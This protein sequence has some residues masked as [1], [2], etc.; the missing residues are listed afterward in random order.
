MK[1]SVI[2][3]VY[4]S[5]EFLPKCLDSILGQD[6]GDFELILVN[7]GTKDG[8][9]AIMEDYARRDTRIRQIHKENG[10]LSSARN[11]GLDIAKGEY[12][13]FV[14]SDDWI[15]PQLLHDAVAAA[16]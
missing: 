6:F 7:D 13:V 8:C 5:A 14:D 3:P 15:E 1:F 11:A 10:G 12:I 4:N 9:P 16:E 2:I